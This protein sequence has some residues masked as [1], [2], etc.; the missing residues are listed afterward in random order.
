MAGLSSGVMAITRQYPGWYR[1]LSRE[2]RGASVNEK[3][4]WR[5]CRGIPPSGPAPSSILMPATM[6]EASSQISAFSASKR[7]SASFGSSLPPSNQAATKRFHSRSIVGAIGVEREIAV[8]GGEQV[9]TLRRE[10]RDR[11]RILGAGACAM[12]G[13]LRGEEPDRAAVALDLRRHRPRMAVLDAIETDHH[14]HVGFQRLPEFGFEFLR[15]RHRC[16]LLLRMMRDQRTAAARV[17]SGIARLLG[18][19]CGC[20][21]RSGCI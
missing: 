20:L 10:G 5:P 7:R 13:L 14:R 6:L 3:R 4:P 1:D 21:G 18:G 15:G 12:V 17:P 9:V 16:F 2:G 8:H 19:P 11:A